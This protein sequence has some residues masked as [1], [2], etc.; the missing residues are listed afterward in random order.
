M[1]LTF[2]FSFLFCCFFPI[3]FFPPSAT[4]RPTTLVEPPAN[5]HTTDSRSIIWQMMIR[6]GVWGS[7][8]HRGKFNP[9]VLSLLILQLTANTLVYGKSAVCKTA[10]GLMCE[11]L[12]SSWAEGGPTHGRDEFERDPACITH[13]PPPNELT[14]VNQEVENWLDLTSPGIR[15]RHRRGG[16]AS[17]APPDDGSVSRTYALTTIDSFLNI[18]VVFHVI[19]DGNKGKLAFEQLTNQI[20]VLNAAFS[21]KNDDQAID[22]QVCTMA[23]SDEQTTKKNLRSGVLACMS[24]KIRLLSLFLHLPISPSSFRK[25][26]AGRGCKRGRH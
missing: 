21:S 18:D 23:G 6:T 16:M 7:R 25:Q 3:L 26:E 9:F 5:L 11:E 12:V 19:H 2:E 22:S 24:F 8:R 10:D 1:C 13:S 14:Q 20:D 17:Q 15:H 4:Q